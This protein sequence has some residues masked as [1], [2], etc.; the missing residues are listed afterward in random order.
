MR[1]SDFPPSNGYSHNLQ[2]PLKGFVEGYQRS[3]P[4]GTSRRRQKW[5]VSHVA[6]GGIRYPYSKALSGSGD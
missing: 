1:I 2:S 4:R 5:K 6:G 3:G